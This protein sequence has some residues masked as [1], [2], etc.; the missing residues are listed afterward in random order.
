MLEVNLFVMLNNAY[1]KLFLDIKCWFERH[2][3]DISGI[4]RSESQQLQKALECSMP[5]V[6]YNK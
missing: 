1:L 4:S 2:G 3:C 6:F 5:E